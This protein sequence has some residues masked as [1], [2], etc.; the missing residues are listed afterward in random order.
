MI[1]W[2]EAAVLLFSRKAF[3]HISSYEAQAQRYVPWQLSSD[4]KSPRRSIFLN[5]PKAFPHAKVCELALQSRKRHSLGEIP[6]F[7]RF[8]IIN[9]I[10]L[11]PSGFHEAWANAWPGAS[12]S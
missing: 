4:E 8:P 11:H 1:F 10:H 3:M 7:L 6:F 5:E 9:D 12:I 2:V